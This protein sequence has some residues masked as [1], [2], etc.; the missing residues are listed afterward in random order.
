[1]SGYEDLVMHR[2]ADEAECIAKMHESELFISRT[3]RGRTNQFV[4]V[5]NMFTGKPVGGDGLIYEE[6]VPAV[7]TF[8]E[9][10]YV[11][12]VYAPIPGYHFNSDPK[13]YLEEN[14]A[15]QLEVIAEYRVQ[16]PLATEVFM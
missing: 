5:D 9:E 1:M 3:I 15:E 6:T 13:W 2:F 7:G 16:P 4:P 11:P 10:G 14:Y 12:P 8:G